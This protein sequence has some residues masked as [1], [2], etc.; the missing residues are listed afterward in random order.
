M[1]IAK[2][3]QEDKNYVDA[4]GIYRRILSLPNS[5][6]KAEAQF[7]IAEATE[8]STKPGSEAAIAQYRLVAER[9]R[10]SE[11][12]GQALAKMV[13][14][15]IEKKD[16]AM[17]NDMLIQIFK[18]YPDEKWLDMMLLKWVMVAYRRG[19]YQTSFDKCQ[20][21]IFQY[22]D[23]PSAATAKTLVPKIEKKLH[24]S[25]GGGGGGNNG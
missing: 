13:D 19:D 4:I 12:A 14:Y 7:H 22:P 16:F 3:K 2:V 15:Y 1:G 24:D 9:Y 8:L 25:G 18:D 17:A 11:Y 6:V 21:L 10:D 20:E 5:Q 23:S